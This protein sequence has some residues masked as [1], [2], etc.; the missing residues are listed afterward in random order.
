MFWRM[1][2]I[3]VSVLASLSCQEQVSQAVQTQLIRSFPV[4]NGDSQFRCGG[5]LLSPDG[6]KACVNGTVV[7]ETSN[8]EVIRRFTTPPG[9]YS[10]Q[11]I[12][13]SP[14]NERVLA[15]INPF[16]DRK[17]S[18]AE[19][20]C[21]INLADGR[22]VGESKFYGDASQLLFTSSAWH[23]PVENPQPDKN[24]A[25]Y[26]LVPWFVVNAVS[27]KIEKSFELPRWEDAMDIFSPDGCRV[28]TVGN[29][30]CHIRDVVTWR[31]VCT[32]EMQPLDQQRAVEFVDNGHEVRGINGSGIVRIWDATT[33]RLL[34]AVNP[35]QSLRRVDGAGLPPFLVPG[36]MRV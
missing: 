7:Y 4:S 35:K 34:S 10:F 18:D 12:A 29:N 6:S 16:F 2:L 22:V 27:G 20:L 3:S 26:D 8:G 23:Y 24:V 1:L 31:M 11:V 30:M 33:G 9:D 25:R 32:L 15:A 13:F 17:S 14:D 36:A 5:I 21:C 28:I 19:T